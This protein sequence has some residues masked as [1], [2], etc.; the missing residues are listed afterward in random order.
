MACVLFLFDGVDLNN[1]TLPN[2]HKTKKKQ[3]HLIQLISFG[4]IIL[5]NL[6]KA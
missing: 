4:F 2:M 1:L 5:Q 6:P 3:K